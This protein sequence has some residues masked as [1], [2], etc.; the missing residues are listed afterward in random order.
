MSQQ[1]S[2]FINKK[3][4]FICLFFL[5]CLSTQPTSTHAQDNVNKSYRF[6]II[7]L[8]H[9]IVL[10]RQYIPFFDY[11]NEHLP[12]SF[13][14]VL[15]KE[16][17]QVV[18]AIENGELDMALL[19]GST[20]MQA[21]LHTELDP[22]VAIRSRD[23]STKTYGIFVTKSDNQ[24]INS[25]NDTQSKSIA[26][27]PEQSTSSFLMPLYFLEKNFITLSKFSKYENL[28]NHDAVARAVLRGEYEVGVLGE[29]FA[30]RFLGKGLKQIEITESFP[31]FLLVARVGVAENVRETFKNF[32]LSIDPKSK[33]FTTKSMAWPEILR[34]GF[35]PV[36]MSD[37]EIFNQLQ[38]ISKPQ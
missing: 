20:F 15:Y 32:L 13:D 7:T 12:W 5:I 2:K 38:S 17:S 27:G 19:G 31:S 30:Q 28:S 8:S 9:P 21:M 24:H 37:Y 11:I 10:Y 6:G 1:F 14:L 3:I 34:Y 25:L 18:K 29:S 26:F 35:A 4:A 23:N 36:T 16:Y 33:N 22:L